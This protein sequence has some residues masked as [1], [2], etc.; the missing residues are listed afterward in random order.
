M[1][2]RKSKIFIAGHKGMV[3]SSIKRKLKKLGY[4]NLLVADKNKINL[5]DQKKVFGYLKKKNRV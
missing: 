2:S 3:G 1:L 4:T 5:L